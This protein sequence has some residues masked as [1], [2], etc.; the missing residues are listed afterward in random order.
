M[1][2]RI[3]LLTPQGSRLYAAGNLDSLQKAVTSTTRLKFLG[4][5]VALA[6]LT[7][8]GKTI[9]SWFGPEF[10]SGYPILLILAA[11]Q[12]LLAAV[13]PIDILLILTGH[14]KQCLIVFS[15][16]L[17]AALL[18]NHVLVPVFDATGAAISALLT[19]LFWNIWL[20]RIVVRQLGIRPSI[21]VSG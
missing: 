4:G 10:A 12:L 21:S 2:K 16:S 20:G 11:S 15:A 13:G 5:L 18:L 19:A 1:N 8:F 14:Q 3:A 6:M 17:P 7:I 9:L